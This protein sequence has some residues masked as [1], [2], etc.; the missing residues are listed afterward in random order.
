M[1]L[2]GNFKNGTIT[3]SNLKIEDGEYKY[4]F[5]FDIN[6]KTSNISYTYNF[7]ETVYFSMFDFIDGKKSKLLDE[8]TTE[9][10]LQ[11]NKEYFSLTTNQNGVNSTIKLTFDIFE[12]KDKLADFLIEL[13]AYCEMLLDN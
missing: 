3:I 6:I 7:G 2:I 8:N 9:N 11:L 10:Y 12:D 5:C 13:K 1:N 4:H